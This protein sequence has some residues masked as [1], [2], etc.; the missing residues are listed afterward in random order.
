ME[1]YRNHKYNY[2]YNLNYA[3]EYNNFMYVIN[4]VKK[5]YEATGEIFEN[6]A[7]F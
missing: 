2:Y 1:L 3:N 7:R 5:I 4:F 6:L